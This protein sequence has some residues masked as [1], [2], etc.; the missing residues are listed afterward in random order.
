MN[1]S[2]NRAETPSRNTP[3][4]AD[5][6]AATAP[7]DCHRDAQGRFIGGNPG[8]PGNPFARQTA[9][10]RK[11]LLSVVTYEEMRIIGADL[12]V[13]AKMGDLAAIKLLF[14]YVLGKPTASVNPDTLDQQEMEQYRQ[15][16]SPAQIMEIMNGWNQQASEVIGLIRIMLPV[17]AHN[18][19]NKIADSLTNPPSEPSGEDA[20]DDDLDDL[21]AEEEEF[22]EEDNNVP[23]EE[24]RAEESLRRQRPEAAPS[25]NGKMNAEPRQSAT[26]P[27]PNRSDGR[28]KPQRS[29]SPNGDNGCPAPK[30]KGER[31]YSRPPGG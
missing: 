6:D 2:K 21:D 28:A 9:E 13:K 18:L 12:V 14:Q 10:L 5:L 7:K 25:T 15:G 3:D 22:E 4:R 27:S 11:A 19:K 31:S 17:V 26:R 29:P 24:P 8:G 20:F 30:P 1:T 23:E 16:M